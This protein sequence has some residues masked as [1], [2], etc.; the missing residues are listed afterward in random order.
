VLDLQHALRRGGYHN[1]P[2]E[3]TGARYLS[4][5]PHD[6]ILPFLYSPLLAGKP[7]RE[8]EKAAR[9]MGVLAQTPLSHLQE[10]L[11]F[12]REKTKRA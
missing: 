4:E 10:Q 2:P 12:T 3:R 1:R 6:P 5:P 7:S 9:R 8:D 11:T